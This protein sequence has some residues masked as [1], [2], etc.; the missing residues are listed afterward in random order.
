MKVVLVG[1][2]G[3]LGKH[4]VHALAEAGHDCLV[5]TRNADPRKDVRLLPRTRLREVDVHDEDALARAI[6]GAGAAVSMAGILNE[7]GFGGQGFHR[8]HVELVEKIVAACH[9]AGIRRLL[10]VS[11][12]NAG[13]GESH[14]L[15]TKGEAEALLRESGLDVTVFR[16]SVIFGPDDSFFNRFAQLLRLAPVMPLAC[17]GARMQP[18]YV[19]DVT[20][21]MVRSL[22]DEETVGK[23]YELAGPRVYT[24]RELVEWTAHTLGLRR[25]VLGLPRFLSRLQ[26]AVMDFVPGKPFSTDNYL[27]LQH[28]NVSDR[29]DLESLGLRPTS[30]EAVVPDYLGDSPRQRRLDASRRRHR[31]VSP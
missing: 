24:L 29:K 4:L 12:I 26:A 31:S 8:V 20:A 2:A 19:G 1:A 25:R 27:S 3:F 10:H 18:V 22:A 15:R 30:I 7:R 11:A 13:Q 5:L 9:S 23:V 16:P 6:E 21:A 14:Y 28:D 17:P